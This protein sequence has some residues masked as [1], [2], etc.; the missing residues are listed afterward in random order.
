MLNSPHRAATVAW[1]S[2]TALLAGALLAATAPS[3]VAAPVAAFPTLAPAQVYVVPGGVTSIR[4]SLTG[5]AGID[6]FCSGLAG[7]GGSVTATI[8]VTPGETLEYNVGNYFTASASGNSSDIRRSPYALADRLVVAGG[9]GS[10]A[11]FAGTDIN[12]SCTGI[13]TGPG[14]GGDGGAPAGLSGTGQDPA[15]CT[16]QAGRPGGGGQLDGPGTAGDTCGAGGAGGPGVFGHGGVGGDSGTAVAPCSHGGAGG[17]GW[18]GGGG[19]GGTRSAVIGSPGGCTNASGNPIAKTIGGGGGGGSSFADPSATGVV[20]TVGVNATSAGVVAIDSTSITVPS[21]PASASAVGAATTATVSWTAPTSD[22]GS[23][24]TGYSVTTTPG[25]AVVAV[26]PAVL[27]T[28]ITGLSAGVTYS[29]DV[30]AVNATGSSTA[31]TASALGTSLTLKASTKAVT[32]GSAATVSGVLKTVA[33]SPLSARSV[34]IL[35]RPAGVA[36]YTTVGTVTTNASGAYALS[37]KP[38]KGT[39]YVAVFLGGAGVMGRS[40]TAVVVSVAPR[41]TFALNDATATRTQ[42]VVFAGV[43]SPNSKLQTVFL[44]RFV[45]GKWSS[46]KSMKLTTAS[47]FRFAWRPTSGADYYFRVLVPARTGYLAAATVKKLLTVA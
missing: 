26:G 10:N 3:A 9:G 1:I 4:V 34:R 7:R 18:Y 30:R 13:R 14:L 24:L 32:Y 39:S 45:A 6:T 29:F 44:Q 5:A 23:P 19:G 15:L 16:F 42:T 38:S 20:F 43:V 36:A 35:G 25:G 8:P 41:V 37:V 47:S 27:S 46:V 33:G 21:P 40:T 2:T 31:T 28:P 22:G 12:G 17:D 11:D